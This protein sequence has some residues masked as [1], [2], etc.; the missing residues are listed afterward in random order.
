M[1]SA[2]NTFSIDFSSPSLPPFPPFFKRNSILCNERIWYSIST[3]RYSWLFLSRKSFDVLV[4]VVEPYRRHNN[5]SRLWNYLAALLEISTLT[6]EMVK[7][8]LLHPW[9]FTKNR[10]SGWNTIT[11]TEFYDQPSRFPRKLDVWGFIYDL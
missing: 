5:L 4:A 1:F 8:I 7:V 3:S 11:S 10:E 2:R 9:T 6:C